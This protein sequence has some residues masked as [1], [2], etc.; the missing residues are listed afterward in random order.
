MLI[1][2][3]STVV[4]N[5]SSSTVTV[6]QFSFGDSPEPSSPTWS[7]GPGDEVEIDCGFLRELDVADELGVSL[8]VFVKCPSD[9]A[10]VVTE[11]DLRVR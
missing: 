10:I 6:R 7:L 2:S 5:E 4:R 1:G 3:E 9:E 8:P 11:E